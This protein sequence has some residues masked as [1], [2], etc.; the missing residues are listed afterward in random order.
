MVRGPDRQRLHFV[1][2]TILPT[3]DGEVADGATLEEGKVYDFALHDGTLI[4]TYEP[5]DRDDYP[6]YD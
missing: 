1:T 3:T 4:A 2:E 6:G 5:V